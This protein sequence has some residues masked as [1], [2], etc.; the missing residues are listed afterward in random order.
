MPPDQW[1]M[2]MALEY[3]NPS[4]VKRTLKSTSMP[5]DQWIVHM[6]LE[7]TNPSFGALS[8]IRGLV[9]HQI[10]RARVGC[11]N[12]QATSGVFFF[13]DDEA[14]AMGVPLAYV[15]FASRVRMLIFGA[16]VFAAIAE[17]VAY[18]ERIGLVSLTAARLQ[19]VHSLR[20]IVL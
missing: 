16:A 13:W 14:N 4:F 7:Y 10:V 9:K 6:A 17:F 3:T 8:V 5:P 20:S 11:Y 2:H 1:I 12:S 15:L 19:M 18:A